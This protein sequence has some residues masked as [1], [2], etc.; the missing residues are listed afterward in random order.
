MLFEV[1]IV[2]LIRHCEPKQVVGTMS[3]KSSGTTMEKLYL[4]CFLSCFRGMFILILYDILLDRK[5]V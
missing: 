3:N 4:V 5:F 2:Y 1:A